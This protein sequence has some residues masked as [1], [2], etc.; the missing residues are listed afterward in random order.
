MHGESRKKEYSLERDLG[1]REESE[2]AV[3]LQGA[4][5]IMGSLVFEYAVQVRGMRG[6]ERR[7]TGKRCF[8][9]YD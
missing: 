1:K 9:S 3:V 8:W 4:K 5:V 7:W 6:R 2:E